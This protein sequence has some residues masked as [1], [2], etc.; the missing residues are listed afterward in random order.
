MI[1]WDAKLWDYQKETVKQAREL[2]R[3]GFKNILIVSPTGS[4]KTV[5]ATHMTDI[6][7]AKQSRVAFV[8]DRLSLIQQTSRTFFDSEIDHGVIQADH[9][10]YQPWKKVQIC[11]QQTLARRKWP[12]ADIIFVD[13]AHTVTE[14]VKN[15]IAARDTVTIGLTATPFTKGLGKHYDAIV[16][17]TTTNK[18]IASGN[19]ANYRIFAASEPDMTGVKVVAGEWDRA[20][21]EKRALEVVGDCVAEY[22]KLGEGKKFICSA[23]DVNHVMELQRQFM[24]AGIVCATYTYK[25]LADDRADIVAEFRKADSNI[26]GLITV[27]AASKGFDVPDIGVVI[28]ARPLRK[29]LAEHIQFFGRGLRSSPGKT[30]CLVLDHSGN[31]KRFWD[32]WNDFFETGAVELDDGKV[33]DK[34]KKKP[35]EKER[36]MAVCPSCAHVHMALPHCPACGHEYPIRNTVQHVAGTLTELIASHNRVA[37]TTEIWTQLCGYAA[38]KRA[39]SSAARKMALALFKQMTGQWPTKDYFDTEAKPVTKEVMGKIK[40]MNIAYS[41]SLKA[42]AK[43][44]V[45]QPTPP[46]PFV[47]N[48]DQLPWEDARGN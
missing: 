29:S 6:A 18:L 32:E 39:E 33:K 16:N 28:M 23:V 13:E 9:P 24:A 14:T 21:T 44:V 34:K 7:R 37:Q 47:G 41:H 27:T 31:C 1:D 4:G 42:R 12:D 38:S 17:V 19:L 8:V 40:S 2:I 48:G 26:R 46:V 25:D 43:Q 22:L 10:M 30:E 11:S 45:A 35:V 3:Q 15:R 5:I 36:E 20:E